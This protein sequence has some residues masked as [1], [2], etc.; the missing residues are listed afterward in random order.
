MITT[1]AHWSRVNQVESA[2]TEDTKSYVKSSASITDEAVH[3]VSPAVVGIV[4]SPDVIEDWLDHV[5]ITLEEFLDQ[6]MGSWMFGYMKALKARN[7]ETVVFCVSDR[8]STTQRLYHRPTG[9]LIC[10][11]PASRLYRLSRWVHEH[12]ERAAFMGSY[13]IKCAVRLVTWYLGTPVRPFLDEVRR[14][15]CSVLL[16]QDY[17]TA[18]FD[19]CVLMGR[20]VGIPVYGTFQG[21]VSWGKLFD[22]IRSRTINRCAGLIIADDAEAERVRKC[23]SLPSNKLARIHNPLD[24]G[25]WEPM[26]KSEAR[27]QTGIPHAAEVAIWH[28]RI[29][30]IYKGLDVLISAWELVSEMRKASDLRLILIGMGPDS[31]HLDTM[32][33]GKNLRGVVRIKKWIHDTN[34]LR[35]YLACADVFVFSSRG[36]GFP[37][38][39]ME[40][41]ACGLPVVASKARG[42]ADIFPRGEESGG[43]LVPT[44]DALALAAGVMRILDDPAVGRELGRR[45]RRQVEENF[46]MDKI[47]NQ[48][49]D[50]LLRDRL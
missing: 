8:T 7:V 22:W 10:L 4:M 18:R 3:P 46:S 39:P 21:G 14:Q 36:E 35:Q 2:L 27:R 24:L 42:I 16:V 1:K 37:V 45:G 12:C 50:L 6:M 44:G 19:M 20:F 28:G 25:V 47:G 38:A 32:V 13:W 5:R 48:L 29:D 43:V 40:A 41:M 9:A 11:L 33:E 31:E 17:E 15:S 23:H 49:S 26:D 30:L 34:V